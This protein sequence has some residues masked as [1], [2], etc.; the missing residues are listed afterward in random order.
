MEKGE[1]IAEGNYIYC[2][3]GT[4]EAINFGPIGI[5]NRDDIVS[6]IGYEGVSCVVSRSPVA[7]YPIS[8]E[9]M[10][11][12]QRVIEKV[13]KDYTVLPVRFS[14]IA[15]SP[16]DIRGLL[17]KRRAEFIGLLRDMD[18]KVELGL[19]V[20]WK[21]M[22]VVFKEIAQ[23]NVDVK[24]LKEKIGLSLSNKA[25]LDRVNLG[26]TV[27]SA[28]KGKKEAEAELVLS[29]LKDVS[30]DIRANKVHGDGMV[31]NAAFLVDRVNAKEFDD[32]VEEL[33][34]KRNR[35]MT[36]RYV[37]PVPPFNFVNIVVEW[38]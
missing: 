11:T 26:K 36:L 9:N 12:H 5:G 10:L 19:K 15:K 25:Y 14:T 2:I 8:R 21:D 27:E 7:D 20:V 37:G 22:G 1:K 3:I 30:F 35:D 38:N 33:E 31:L 18:N 23:S 13:M 34:R 6:T 28:L 24:R 32:R 16:E 4:D 17:R 29:S